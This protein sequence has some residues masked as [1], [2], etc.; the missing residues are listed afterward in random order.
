[1]SSKDIAGMAALAA[2]ASVLEI[3]PFDLR[4]PFPLLN[5]LTFD[6]TG[7]PIAVAAILYG[8]VAAFVTAGIAG[9][10]IATRNPVSAAFKTAAEMSTAV[11]LAL[12]LWGLRGRRRETSSG[13]WA[14]LG[15]A[16]AVAIASRVTV[17]TGFNL[18]FLPL[19]LGIPEAVVGGL[20]YPIAIFNAAQGAINVIPAFLIVR[21]LPPDLKPSWLTWGAG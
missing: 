4:V 21:G 11:P 5:F 2:M 13:T 19:L 3:I 10:T 20:L 15:L 18:V 12:T 1:M 6:P 16:G 14:L 8:P 17:M 9:I 7:I